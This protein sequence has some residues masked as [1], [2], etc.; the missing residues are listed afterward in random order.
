MAEELG[1]TFLPCILANLHRAPNLLSLPLNENEV[2]K[3]N[4]LITAED[5]DVCVLPFSALGGP[6][7]L[8]FIS[9]GILVLAV[10]ENTSLMQVISS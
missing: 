3:A 6:A 1:H 10:E 5:V 4:Q 8:S 2:L 9:R 7:A